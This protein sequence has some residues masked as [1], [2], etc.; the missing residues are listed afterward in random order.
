MCIEDSGHFVNRSP[1]YCQWDQFGVVDV[2][3][4]W[5]DAMKSAPCVQRPHEHSC[6]PTGTARE[7]GYVH[8]LADLIERCNGN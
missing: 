8:A 5:L 2:N 6:E 4:I 7:S 1:E 3:H